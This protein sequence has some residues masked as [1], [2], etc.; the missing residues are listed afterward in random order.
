MVEKK[1]VLFPKRSLAAKT[2]SLSSSTAEI[3]FLCSMFPTNWVEEC[4]EAAIRLSIICNGWLSFFYTYF[5]FLKYNRL[6]CCEHCRTGTTALE[7]S[8]IE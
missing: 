6:F 5:Q 4:L 7:K 8:I 3:A 2:T 1:E